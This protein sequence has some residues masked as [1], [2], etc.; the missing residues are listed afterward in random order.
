MPERT[1]DSRSVWGRQ[2]RIS[3]M[4][5]SANLLKEPW[6]LLASVEGVGW[7]V[8]GALVERV[9]IYLDMAGL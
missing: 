7:T 4:S 9:A 5:S 8:I 2:R 6:W 3:Q 1:K